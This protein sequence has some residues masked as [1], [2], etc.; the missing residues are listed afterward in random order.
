MTQRILSDIGEIG[1]LVVLAVGVCL[2]PGVAVAQAPEDAAASFADE[3]RDAIDASAP[4][5]A[6]AANRLQLA[7]TL[8]QR[9]QHDRALEALL[10]TLDKA[11]G[12]MV[13]LADGSLSPVGEEANRLIGTLP[14]ET[15]DLY[16]KQYGPASER[17][18]EEALA[19]GRRDRVEAVALQFRYTDAGR[20]A[21]VH[22]AAIH[23]DRAEFGLAFRVYEKIFKGLDAGSR[24][25]MAYA[26]AASGQIDRA[27]EI[28]T[29]LADADL[30]AN[31]GLLASREDID[32]LLARATEMSPQPVVADWRMPFGDPTSSA[33]AEAGEPILLRRW[34]QPLAFRMPLQSR[35]ERLTLD[36]HDNHKA[37]VPTILPLAIGDRVISRTLHGTS[38]FSISEGRLL[39]ESEDQSLEQRL[40]LDPNEGYDP[41]MRQIMRMRGQF[42]IDPRQSGSPNEFGPLVDT[43][44]RNGVYGHVTADDRRLYV[45][46]HDHEN[47]QVGTARF[48]INRINMLAPDGSFAPSFN[49]LVAYDLDTGRLAW[50]EFG[51]LGGGLTAS[52]FEPPLAGFYF[53]GPPTPDGNELFVI[54]EAEKQ[55]RLIALDPESGQERW[56]RPIAEAPVGIAQ[57]PVRQHWPAQVAVGRGVLVCPTTVGWLVAIERASH[58]LLWATRYAPPKP[59]GDAATA[60]PGVTPAGLNE[61]WAPAAPVIHRNRIYFTPP[62]EQRLV[63]LDLATGEIKWYRNRDDGLYL[64]GVS[65]DMVLIVGKASVNALDAESGD[66]RWSVPLSEVPSGRATVTRDR[67]YLPLRGDA[68][69]SID[70]QRGE[71]V[72]QTPLPQGDVPLGNLLLHR[73]TLLSLSPEG[74]TAYEERSKFIAAIE[75]RLQQDP[76]DVEALLRQAQLRYVDGAVEEAATTLD[77]LAS[78]GLSTDQAERVRSLQWDVLAAIVRA[79]GATADKRL[80]TL[81][82]LARSDDERFLVRRLDAD[83]SLAA[84][85]FADAAKAYLSL[86]D[87]EPTRTIDEEHGRRKVSL[88][89]WLAGR[90]HEVWTKSDGSVREAVNQSIEHLLAT[91]QSPAEQARIAK[92]C[93][94]HP[95][96]ARI[97]LSLANEDIAAGRVAAGEMRL[98]R[99]SRGDDPEAATALRALSDAARDRGLNDDADFWTRQV[100]LRTSAAQDGAKDD[101]EISRD[102]ADANEPWGDYRFTVLRT[103][104]FSTTE[105]PA[106]LKFVSAELP[107]Y[108][109]R[110]MKLVPDRLAI[111][112]PNGLGLE[113]LIP[114]QVGSRSGSQTVAIAEGHLLF[115]LYRGML[116]AVSP[117]EN[118]LLWSLAVPSETSSRYVSERA[119]N[120]MR[121]ANSLVSTAGSVFRARL[122]GSIAAANATY[123][124]IEG[125]RELTVV[126][127]TTG[128]WLWSRSGW[129]QDK[130][131]VGT[132]SLLYVISGGG[133]PARVL[134][135]IDGQEVELRQA[136]SNIQHAVAASGDRLL[137]V[138]QEPAL[139]LPLGLR[140]GG[141]AAVSLFDPFLEK[142]VWRRTYPT[143]TLFE[144][145]ADGR[146]VVLTPAGE[147]SKLDTA[148]GNLSKL[149]DLPVELLRRQSSV[150]FLEDR[151]GAYAIVNVGRPESSFAGLATL[152]V[153]G[154]IFAFDHA[155]GRL[156]WRKEV[157]HRRLVC[158]DFDQMPAFLFVDNERTEARNQNVGRV[159]LLALDKRL[160]EPVLDES[161]LMNSTPVFRA[162][163]LEPERRSIRLTAFNTQLR[164]HAVEKDAAPAP[165]A[166]NSSSD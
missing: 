116:Q 77:G 53:F 149:G 28:A 143:E 86:I 98:L 137:L 21:L 18:L 10:Y 38:V 148:T 106:S 117:L 147:L 79:D 35:I 161:H 39:W 55:I 156:R 154:E 93:R 87:G 91:K 62:E 96:A 130:T 141:G 140:V 151:R 37:T 162:F 56:M 1:S 7:E 160:G 36:L 31:G 17:A 49:R 58:S 120:P 83:R 4:H 134:R 157:S 131:V 25:R 70:L 99:L 69:L 108:R 74:L 145:A 81:K 102:V 110:S 12:G 138:E 32:R 50:P 150:V 45:V 152:A 107:F 8:I 19:S 9:G 136:A 33:L 132:D 166:E 48:A 84:G 64:A 115:M 60:E 128:E 94:F 42:G 71:I 133:R 97:E 111:S 109:D 125:R 11:D 105:P 144:V 114:L 51:G 159:N 5:D 127:A 92:I 82:Q 40:A 122:S 95:A 30:T 142:T 24:L 135:A 26:A 80:S 27:R 3:Y 104:G 164:L 6:K 67:M 44:F 76:Q 85:S 100:T 101:K 158:E 59:G 163:S 29:A 13:R 123:V 90:L 155:D 119:A 61:R 22:L 75:S 34:H 47:G 2:L 63:C 103:N 68:L 112:G 88:D 65:D 118:R 126:D 15:L 46:E 23:F 113:R 89:A 20:K 73:G 139:R 124:A 52:A 121:S 129:P 66:V 16:R 153:N 146:L 57:D 14:A 41:T 72:G 165:P 43:L 54:G 78:R